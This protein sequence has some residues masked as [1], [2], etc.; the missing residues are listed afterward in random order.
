MIALI[1]E[2]S[3]LRR[4][5]KSHGNTHLLDPDEVDIDLN[6]F[7]AEVER[8]TPAPESALPDAGMT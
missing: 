7:F 4:N 6:E 3:E 2:K 1:N 8:Q 5:L